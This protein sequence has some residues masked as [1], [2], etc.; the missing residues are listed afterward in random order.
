MYVVPFEPTKLQRGPDTNSFQG[1]K[2]QISSSGGRVPR[3][4]RDGKE[5]FYI[6]SNNAI[7]A[8]EVEGSGTSFNVGRSQQLFVAPVNPFA[9]T[10]DVTPDGQRFVMSASPEQEEPPLVLMLNWT[11]RLQAK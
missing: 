8:A 9:A 11:A 3:W 10:Y 1:G 7:M 4:R 2:W 5:L 6:A